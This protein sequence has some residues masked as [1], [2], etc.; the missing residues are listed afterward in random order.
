M[1]HLTQ[2]AQFPRAV[3]FR[4]RALRII[5]RRVISARDHTQGGPPHQAQ[6]ALV[7]KRDAS[8]VTSARRQALANRRSTSRASSER[9]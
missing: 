8:I 6:S 4:R 9:P 7:Q 5:A 3:S 2:V 1:G